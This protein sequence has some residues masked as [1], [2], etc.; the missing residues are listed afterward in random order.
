[1]FHLQSTDDYISRSKFPGDFESDIRFSLG[2]PQNS[3]KH[4]LF[5]PQDS[6]RVYNRCSRHVGIAFCIF[7][8]QREGYKRNTPQDPTVGARHLVEQTVKR[9]GG[10]A[11]E[12]VSRA[13][14]TEKVC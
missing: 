6:L 5:S 14:V 10:A 4:I 3:L 12:K 1:M 8:C 9:L 7:Q 11:A 13:A 2:S